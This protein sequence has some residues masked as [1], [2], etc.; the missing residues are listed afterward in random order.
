M[1]SAVWV[2]TTVGMGAASGRR[3]TRALEEAP[4]LLK[5]P[6]AHGARARA[7]PGEQHHR[8]QGSDTEPPGEVGVIVCV[9]RHHACSSGDLLGEV[10][11]G[12]GHGPTGL[13]PGGPEI[14]ED[15]QVALD[16]LDLEA[17]LVGRAYPHHGAAPFS[18]GPEGV[19][20]G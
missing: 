3:S 2:G 6:D 8:R 18:P 14:D 16:H 1:S 13:A 7:T 4:V 10:A 5:R 12:Q 20:V 17:L 9:H 19:S 15:R 11:Q